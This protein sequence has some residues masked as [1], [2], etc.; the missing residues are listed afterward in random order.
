M[1]WKGDGEK[2]RELRVLKRQNYT[3]QGDKT[4]HLLDEG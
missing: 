4:D 1:V 3:G 2:R